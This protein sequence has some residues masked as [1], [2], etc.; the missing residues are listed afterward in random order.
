[1]WLKPS[2]NSTTT[3][4]DGA[5]AGAPTPGDGSSTR[6]GNAPDQ[7]S[8]GTP[9]P[10]DPQA[11]QDATDEPK[12][13]GVTKDGKVILNV[14]DVGELTRLPGVGRKRAEAIVRLRERLGRLRKA[15][16]LLRVKGIG[17]KTLKKM[18]PYLVLDPPE[19]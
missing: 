19:E 3:G 1:V 4:H 17:V 14:A 13:S 16:D 15:T 2:G 8:P 7:S 5:R 6:S 11:D 12:R 9:A 18:L 10:G